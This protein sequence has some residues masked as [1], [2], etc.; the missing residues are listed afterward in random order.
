MKKMPVALCSF[1]CGALGLFLG[2]ALAEPMP[3][4]SPDMGGLIFVV[5]WLKNCCPLISASL[6]AVMLAN[7]PP[8]F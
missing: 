1:S 2:V 3:A 7:S 8:I 5:E 6:P 4:S